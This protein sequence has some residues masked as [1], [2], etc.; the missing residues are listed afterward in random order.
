MHNYIYFKNIKFSNY[1]FKTT[2]NKILKGGYLVAP[3]ASALVNIYRDKN[4]YNSLKKAD[5]VIC[6]SGF[7]CIL[8]RFFRKIKL[9]KFSGYLFLKLFLKSPYCKKYKI[10]SIDPNNLEKKININFL[11]NLNFRRSKNL[12]CKCYTSR[13]MRDYSLLNEIKTFKPDIILIN[14]G[15]GKQEVLA[16]FLKKNIKFKVSILCLGAAI[17]FL[18][19]KQAPINDF[20]D[21]YY[22]G[23]FLRI[24]YNK[25]FITRVLR[26]FLLVRF[27]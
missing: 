12:T 9:Q 4:Y 8:V 3:A 13:V 1:N 24:I 19:K 15:G 5:I 21:K 23:W 26:S 7:F 27:F 6:D 17:G 11:Y 22:L 14:I 18:T 16:E 2:L 10:L 25:H 20:Y